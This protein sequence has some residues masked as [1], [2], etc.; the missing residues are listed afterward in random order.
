MKN[1][2]G[3][4]ILG[5]RMIA[6]SVFA[7]GIELECP[8]VYAVEVTN[9]DASQGIK[10]VLSPISIR[11]NDNVSVDGEVIHLGD[12][13]RVIAGEQ[14]VV[15]ELETL[16]VAKSAGFGL[17]RMIDGGSI[18]NRYLKP[19]AAHYAIDYE[20]KFIHVTTSSL[21]LNN[22]SLTHLIE[23]FI[24]EIPRLPNE[25]HHWEIAQAPAK[26]LIPISE[27]FY[28][29]SFA[30]K[31]RKGKVDLNFAIRNEKRVLRNIPI[32]INLRVEQLVL[33]VKKPIKKDEPLTLENVS[34]ENRETTLM[35]DLAIMEPKNQLGLLSKISLM[36]GR[37]I[38]PRMIAMPPLVKR[39]QESKIVFHN[40]N[41]NVSTDAICREDGIAGQ[42]ISA[43]NLANNRLVR[44][45][46]KEDGILEPIPG[47]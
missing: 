28:E 32:T 15:A 45:R 24:A 39:G 11:F 22:D 44:V 18:Y 3:I 27:H 47:G 10:S 34:I 8:F 17:T 12:I 26:I 6:L 19:Y 5:L 38:T 14:K 41:V 2:I 31:K 36:P 33:V 42:I 25:K 1:T 35:A 4:K 30:S 20:Q 29:L 21:T 16:E 46:V 40:G 37:I 23:A 13:A 9:Q 7:L 43:K